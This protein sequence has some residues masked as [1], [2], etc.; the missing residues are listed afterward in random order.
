MILPR[1]SRRASRFGM[2][3]LT[4]ALFSTAVEDRLQAQ[5]RRGSVYAI[6]GGTLAHQRESTDIT[7][8]PPVAAPA[9]TTRGWTIALGVFAAR[10]ISLEGELATTGVMSS[11]QSGRYNMTFNE[12]RQD[13]FFGANVRYHVRRAVHVE[14]VA[15]FTF[16]AHDAGSQT[17]I[18]RFF[19]QQLTIE[20]RIQLDL[21]IG[22]AA[23]AGLDL[24]LGGRHVALV[25]TSR[26]RYRLNSDAPLIESTYAD[27]FPRVTI[28]VGVAGRIDF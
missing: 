26:I 21:P 12:D 10:N 1:N 23:S 16:I 6:V 9:G 14:P 4:L 15:G 13:T 27:S 17:E 20:P 28:T 3:V 5:E 7:T 25:P 24:R 19:P 8:K 11:R 22:F 2:A 18:Q